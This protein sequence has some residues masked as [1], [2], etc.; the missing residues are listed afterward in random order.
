M[1]QQPEDGGE[2]GAP[3]SA[4]LNPAT[5]PIDDIIAAAAPGWGGMSSLVRA[6]LSS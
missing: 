4:V 6:P 2:S 1:L 3:L 5:V